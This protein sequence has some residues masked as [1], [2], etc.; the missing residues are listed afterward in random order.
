MRGGYWLET[1]YY[2][3]ICWEQGNNKSYNFKCTP[4]KADDES[5][6]GNLDS[7]FCP[8]RGSLIP[9]YTR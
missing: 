3:N 9:G 5:C 1:I 8:E 2:D 7:N 4:C 6:K